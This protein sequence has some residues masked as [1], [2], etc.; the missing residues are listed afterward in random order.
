MAVQVLVIS[1][2]GINCEEET[3][4]A[5]NYFG[6][7][8]LKCTLGDLIK[9]K[10][11]LRE[12]QILVLPGGFSYG[13]EINS[14]QVMALKWRR[15]LR[16]ELLRFYEDNKLILG[17]CNGFQILA[18]LGV[19]PDFN[20]NQVVSLGINE[21][22]EF[23]D[24]WES[25]ILQKNSPCIWTKGLPENFDLPVRHGQGRL[26]VL[27]ENVLPDHQIVLTYQNNV[28]GSWKNVAGICDPKGLVLGLMPHPES[29]FFKNF[30]PAF[31]DHTKGIQ[32]SPIAQFFKNGVDYFQKS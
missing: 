31:Y 30:H 28:N 14:G 3:A 23:I 10:N 20:F 7:N 19:L 8:V 11:L 4:F 6:A 12:S 15:Y 29:Y 26:V 27:R 9:N 24:R 17:I 18:H 21:G 16:E 1:G 13:D 25:L 22:G 32:V 2:D 5:F